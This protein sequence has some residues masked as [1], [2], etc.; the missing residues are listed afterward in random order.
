MFTITNSQQKAFSKYMFES[1]QVRAWKHFVLMFPKT[2]MKMGDFGVAEL[3]NKCIDKA[4]SYNIKKREDVIGFLELMGSM[5]E[6]FDTDPQHAWTLN[7]L[8]I[9]NLSGTDKVRRLLK[10]H[11]P[12]QEFI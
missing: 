3:V 4:A 5:G 7:I 9:R 1:F 6:D 10:I 12:K 8:N 2:A 11:T